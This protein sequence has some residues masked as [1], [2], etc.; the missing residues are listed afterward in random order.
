MKKI[1]GFIICIVVGVIGEITILRAGSFGDDALL[2]FIYAYMTVFFIVIFIAGVF[3][4]LLQ[5]YNRKFDSESISKMREA[6]L[7]SCIFCVITVLVIILFVLYLYSVLHTSG[8]SSTAAPRIIGVILFGYILRK[9]LQVNKQ[10][11]KE[12]REAEEHMRAYGYTRRP[13]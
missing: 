12:L 4:L 9:Q 1:M 6:Y 7:V 3:M 13:R 10:L 11:K 8:Y 5:I 2:K